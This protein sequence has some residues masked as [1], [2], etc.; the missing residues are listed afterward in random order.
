MA[1]NTF[2]FA[3]VASSA[4]VAEMPKTGAGR[5]GKYGDVNPFTEPLASSF[6]AFEKGE[7]AGRQI[8]LPGARA[9]EAVYLIRKAADE[10]SIGARVYIQHKGK[11]VTAKD[12]KNIR[13]NVTVL[14]SGK[15]R[16]QKKDTETP[17][18]VSEATDDTE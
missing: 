13:G 8:T 15:N 5:P 12:A 11:N 1:D 6:E 17:E 14:F 16:K 2:D 10:L 9:G 4:K 7:N 3:S 18:P